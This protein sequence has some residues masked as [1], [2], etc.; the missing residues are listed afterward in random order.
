MTTFDIEAYYDGHCP[1]CR[2]EVIVLR[3]LDRRQRI[4]FVDIAEEMF[5]AASVGVPGPSQSGEGVWLRASQRQAIVAAARPRSS[6][7]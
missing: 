1:L 3:R 5:D 2:H 6:D 4:R 7:G